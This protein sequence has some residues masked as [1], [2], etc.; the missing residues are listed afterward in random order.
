MKTK[1]QAILI[2][3]H[4]TRDV[5]GVNEFIHTVNRL[6]ARFKNNELEY[7][8]LEFAT[9]TIGQTIEKL[10]NQGCREILALP[11]MLTSAGHGKNDIPSELNHYSHHFPDLNIRY[12]RDLSIHPFML[13]A[14]Q[15]R[16]QEAE[17]HAKNYRRQDSMLLVVGRGTSDPDANSNISKISR[18]LWEGM[19]FSW[20]ETCFSGV[21]HPLVPEALDRVT[22]LGYQNI[23][24]FPY[25]LFTGILI[26]RIYHAVDEAQ[27]AHPQ[28]NFIKAPYLND[29]DK[30]LDTLVER[31]QEV[32]S[33]TANMNCMM[34]KYREQIIGFEED[35]G[36]P[37]QGHHFHV[38]GIGIDHKH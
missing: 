12:G 16:I 11:L 25:F 6:R 14:A 10:Y 3:G 37:Q 15:E 1:Q 4:G 28:I 23:I 30:V 19:H 9:P 18:L 31:L 33:G 2:V 27:I 38:R 20:A 17:V 5:N 7:G 13:Q 26:E 34:C 21:C 29:H 36:K 8:F 32:I 35:Q 22:K 24:V